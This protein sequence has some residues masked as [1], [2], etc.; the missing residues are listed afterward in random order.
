MR[1]KN[2][3][4][5]CSKHKKKN[6]IHRDVNPGPRDV[7]PGP[8]I[9]K[10]IQNDDFFS[11]DHELYWTT[12][13]NSFTQQILDEFSEPEKTQLTRDNF[14]HIWTF[15]LKTPLTSLDENGNHPTFL[16]ICNR[17]TSPTNVIPVYI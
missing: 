8:Q 3:Q 12:I 7:N 15:D 17:L 6:D 10:K 14:G 4:N 11:S 1:I 2:D 13:L 5:K 9:S 16:T